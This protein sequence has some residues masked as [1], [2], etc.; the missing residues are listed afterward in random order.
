MGNDPLYF[1]DLTLSSYSHESLDWQTPA[2]R[3]RQ[4]WNPPGSRPG[5]YHLQERAEPDLRPRG[6][7]VRNQPW[8]Q[9]GLGAPSDYKITTS[10][11]AHGYGALDC[12]TQGYDVRRCS[13]LLGP[14][15]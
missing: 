8:R 15:T 12:H 6:R 4:A 14:C 2:D 11:K 5:E 3:R 1:P 7:E 9:K 13:Q 10:Y